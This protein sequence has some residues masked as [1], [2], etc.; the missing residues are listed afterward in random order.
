MFDSTLQVWYACGVSNHFRTTDSAIQESNA[1]VCNLASGH[2][3]AFG[4]ANL[5]ANETRE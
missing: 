1:G 3:Q 2:C 4:A 5:I